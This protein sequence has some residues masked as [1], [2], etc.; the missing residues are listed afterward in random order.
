MPGITAWISSANVPL[1]TANTVMDIEKVLQAQLKVLETLP[2]TADQEAIIKQV[3]TD[4]GALVEARNDVLDEI[5]NGWI[6]TLDYNNTRPVGTP[7]L[8]NFRLLAEKGAYKGSIDFTGNAS[9]TFYNSRPAGPNAQTLR[10]F[11]FAAQLDVPIGDVT[12]TGKFLLSFGGRYERLLTDEPIAGATAVVRKG[13]IAM[14]Q[15]KLT[16]PIRGTAFKIPLSITFANRT[17]LNKEKEVRGNF[18]FTFDL[19]SILAKFNPFTQK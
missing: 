8:S 10:D 17:E 14:G 11:K 13:D 6:A 4:F 18:G 19:D 1:T 7:S 5:S 16:I 15:L 2:L 12:K 9:L 3:G